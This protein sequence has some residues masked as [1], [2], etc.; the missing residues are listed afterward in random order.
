[1]RPYS[2]ILILVLI[3]IIAVPI[4]AEDKRPM[5]I[6]TAMMEATCKIVGNGS[7]GSGFILGTPDPNNANVLF[8]TLVTAHHV[9]DGVKGDQ[10][11][12]VLRRLIDRDKQ[13]YQRVEVP[14]EIRKNAKQLWTKHRDVDL[15]AMFIRL[16]Q[17]CPPTVIPAVE[18]VPSVVEG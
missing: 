2:T 11:I 7:T 6:N 1:M 5:N 17:G 4:F 3:T 13:D 9:L 12:L 15:A 8:F 16:P 10:V 14:I 18:V